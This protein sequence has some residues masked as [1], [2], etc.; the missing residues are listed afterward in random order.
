MST[1][2]N[3]AGVVIRSGGA[4]Y[5]RKN[6]RTISFKW[7]WQC[8]KLTNSI[9]TINVNAI[10]IAI[11][12]TIRSFHSSTSFAWSRRIS[13]SEKRKRKTSRCVRV[14]YIIVN[15][16]R[17]IGQFEISIVSL[18]FSI[19]SSR[20]CRRYFNT[21]TGI[22]YAVFLVIFG[23]IVFIVDVVDSRYPFPQVRN[24]ST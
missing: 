8:I 6:L 16:N 20:V 24:T 3:S 2:A 14:R 9:E 21:V 13:T 19:R 22:I 1:A 15:R 18:P 7:T 11:A 10:R 17:S 12:T 5:E 4:T 23:S